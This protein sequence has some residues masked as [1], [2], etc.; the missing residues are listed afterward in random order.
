MLAGCPA[1][2]TSSPDGCLPGYA[3]SLRKSSA[4]SNSDRIRGKENGTHE[5]KATAETKGH[6]RHFS[7]ADMFES[8]KKRLKLQNPHDAEYEQARAAINTPLTSSPAAST[9]SRCEKYTADQNNSQVARGSSL[10]I[11]VA[12]TPTTEPVDSLKKSLLKRTWSKTKHVAKLSIH[13]PGSKLKISDPVTTSISSTSLACSGRDTPTP[14]P[15]TMTTGTNATSQYY[16]SA[17]PSSQP[18]HRPFTPTPSNDSGPLQQ[19]NYEFISGPAPRRGILTK[20]GAPPSRNELNTMVARQQSRIVDLTL[21]NNV[22]VNQ[23][24]LLRSEVQV[25]KVN[26]N[27]NADFQGNSNSSP[28]T[29]AHVQ[30]ADVPPSLRP[31]SQAGD[32]QRVLGAESPLSRDEMLVPDAC[33]T[34]PTLRQSRQSFDPEGWRRIIGV[35]VEREQRRQVHVDKDVDMA[36]DA[37][38]DQD[39]DKEDKRKTWMTCDS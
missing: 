6:K 12:R 25:M 39:M 16:A 4:T 31:A 36:L 19:E 20:L 9:E 30:I 10:S 27:N 32:L 18:S 14:V 5:A 8:V 11:D 3:S 13:S 37:D 28:A 24:E 17:E 33:T 38:V 15:S 35:K 21:Q 29:Y 34:R 2:E 22:L 23:I 7:A 26:S 1:D